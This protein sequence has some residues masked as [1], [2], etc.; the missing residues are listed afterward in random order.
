[1]SMSEGFS[2]GI[3]NNAESDMLLAAS[4]PRLPVWVNLRKKWKRH[5]VT[6]HI[7]EDT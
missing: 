6:V 4:K 1:M 2:A 5:A 7:S 3:R